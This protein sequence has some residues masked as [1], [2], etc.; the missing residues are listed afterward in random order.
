[1]DNIKKKRMSKIQRQEQILESARKI[2]IEKGFNGSTTLEIAQ[3][4]EISEVTLFRY[5]SS[6][7]EIFIK[8]IEPVLI[9]TLRKA[10]NISNDLTPVERLKYILTD[11]IK[12]IS[13][14]RDLI[15]LVLMESN[16][17]NNLIS[18]NIIGQITSILEGTIEKMFLKNID[19]SFILRLLMGNILSFLFMPITDDE[20]IASFVD[21]II[22]RVFE[23]EK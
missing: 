1:V 7:Q 16:I 10:I 12:F 20:S 23:V 6:K 14:N 22:T 5:F 9:E 2:F 4:A 15:K 3:R 17:Q 21:Q 19:K 11:R 13:D 8:S 18:I